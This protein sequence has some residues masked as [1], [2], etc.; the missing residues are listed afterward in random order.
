M[1]IGR[2]VWT[3]WPAMFLGAFA[4][5]IS[6]N[7]TGAE[8]GDAVATTAPTSAPAPITLADGAI[9]F[10]PPAGWPQVGAVHGGKAVGFALPN[11]GQMVVNVDKQEVSLAGD[12]NAAV[13]IGQM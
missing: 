4:M 5:S 9:T 1:K 8:P 3:V 12:N 13:K 11:V 2:T 10:T 7:A 6:P